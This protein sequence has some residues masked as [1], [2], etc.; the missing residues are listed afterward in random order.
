MSDERFKAAQ[1]RWQVSGAVDDE[2]ALLRESTRLGLSSEERLRFAAHLGAPAARLCLGSGWSASEPP[3]RETWVRMAWH[4]AD[5]V[6]ELCLPHMP[7]KDRYVGPPR[8]ALAATRAWILAP[9]PAAATHAL[10]TADDFW[11]DPKTFPDQSR[12]SFYLVLDACWHACRSV[13]ASEALDERGREELEEHARYAEL[14]RARGRPVPDPPGPTLREQARASG[15]AARRALEAVLGWTAEQA[16]AESRRVLVREV[17]PWLLGLADPVRNPASAVSGPAGEELRRLEAAAEAAPHDL[18]RARELVHA[19]ELAGWTWEGRTIQQWEAELL[20]R[21]ANHGRAAERLAAMGIRCL[22]TIHKALRASVAAYR[23]EGR[24][25]ALD[26][27]RALGPR[28][29]SLLP[30]LE[31]LQAGEEVDHCRHELWFAMLDLGPA[32]AQ[33][34]TPHFLRQL[35][36]GRWR[37]DRAVGARGL[38]RAAARE[39][40]TAC[41]AAPPPVARLAAF[42]LVSG[43]WAGDEVLP[44]LRDALACGEEYDQ[45]SAVHSVVRLGRVAGFVSELSRAVGDPQ[46]PYMVRLYGA[47]ALGMLRVALEDQAARAAL[48]VMAQDEHPVLRAEAEQALEGRYD[49]RDGFRDPLVA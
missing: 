3:D 2:A 40:L 17:C 42:A 7:T 22:P 15:E 13:V 25:Q 20:G 14:M 32:G 49:E 39:V 21:G 30:L 48:A 12:P 10:R 27:A 18:E 4:V 34:A 38:L 46:R 31:E 9:G 26:M 1:R 33:Q 19:A 41:L 11:C 16:L 47:R 37:S 35:R 36:E 8:R 6:L 44:L 5:R 28:A 43:G 24:S 23:R 45:Q 29:V